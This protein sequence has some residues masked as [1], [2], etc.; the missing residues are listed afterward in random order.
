MIQIWRI[1]ASTDFEGRV[2]IDERTIADI[3]QE[4][5]VTFGSMAEKG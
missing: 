5:V 4:R 2:F 3:L 1:F